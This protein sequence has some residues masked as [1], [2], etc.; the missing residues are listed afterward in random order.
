[1]TLKGIAT[2]DAL[3]GWSTIRNLSDFASDLRG[4]DSGFPSFTLV[5]PNYGRFWS[6]FSGGQSQ[7]PIDSVVGG[8]EL[9]KYLYEALVVS[10][11]WSTS[12][13]IILYDEH[14]GFYDHVVPPE[15][16]PPGDQRHYAHWA[17]DTAAQDFQFDRLGVRV[18]VVVVSP[19]IPKG[20]VDHSEYDHTSIIA[21]LSH[22]FSLRW[23]TDRSRSARPLDPLFSLDQMRTDVPT[24]LP[25]VFR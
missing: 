12:A 11:I 19:L 18:P 4:A 23:L 24:T 25:G 3:N 16:T 13:L 22:R 7:H 8:E 6:D 9:I 20:T 2:E 15:A 10:P 5:E 1:M 14:G 21:T 17:E